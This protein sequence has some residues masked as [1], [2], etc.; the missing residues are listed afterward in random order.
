MPNLR[1]A[2]KALRQS[3]KRTAR[4]LD[5]KTAYKKA[6]K[7]VHKSVAAGEKDMTEQIRLAQ[8]ALG[9]AT[10]SGIIKRNAAARKLSRLVKKTRVTAK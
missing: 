10:K 5:V 6:M 1:N 8:K 4:N 7:A 9:K 3:K 2:K